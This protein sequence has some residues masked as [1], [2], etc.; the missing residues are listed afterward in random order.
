MIRTIGICPVSPQRVRDV[1][2]IADGTFCATLPVEFGCPP[3]TF[4]GGKLLTDAIALKCKNVAPHTDPY[5]GGGEEPEVYFSLFWLV[6]IP[7]HQRLWLQVG[8]ASVEMQ[9]G[10][11]VVFSD[12]IMH[13]V[14]ASRQWFGCAWQIELPPMRVDHE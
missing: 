12:H 4:V 6:D 10:D 13:S 8:E 1:R 2:A 11:F 3:R 14:Q 9:K 5:V 7:Q